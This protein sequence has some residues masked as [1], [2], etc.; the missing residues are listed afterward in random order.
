MSLRDTHHIQRKRVKEWNMKVKE[1]KLINHETVTK[2]R[3]G[4]AVLIREK[5]DFKTKIV[6]RENE[7]YFILIWRLIHQEERMSIN[8]CE[9]NNRV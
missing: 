3:A 5:L 1:W 9:P 6:T 7:G 2:M 4:V 8:I